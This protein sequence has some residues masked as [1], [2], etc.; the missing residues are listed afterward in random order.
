MEE[1]LDLSDISSGKGRMSLTA[2]L[3]D[4]MGH[5]SEGVNVLDEKSEPASVRD[6]AL[7]DKEDEGEK[8]LNVP[9]KGVLFILDSWRKTKSSM[10][11]LK[12]KEVLVLYDECSRYQTASDE[13]GKEEKVAIGSDISRGLLINKKQY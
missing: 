1:I 3:L 6:S 13:A 11:K 12:Q 4:K 5:S 2:M 7:V 10:K 9:Q 8:S